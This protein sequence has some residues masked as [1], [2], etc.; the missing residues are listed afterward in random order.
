MFVRL[1]FCK[2]APQSIE[3][4]KRIFMKDVVPVVRNQK[5]NAN[6]RLLEPT[7]LS[8]DFISMTEWETQADAE[9]YGKSGTYKQLVSL[10]SSYFTEA[11]VLKTYHA[12]SV[13]IGTH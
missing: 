13:L 12:E 6:I 10:L 3:E 9:A 11:P 2:F 7:D 4:A 1:T 5:G 8:N